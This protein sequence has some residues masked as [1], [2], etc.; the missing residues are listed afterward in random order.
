MKGIF[1]NESAIS[2]MFL[3]FLVN[4]Q[5]IN[6]PFSLKIKNEVKIKMYPVLVVHEVVFDV[7]IALQVWHEKFKKDF[8]Y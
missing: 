2:R 8:I 6:F 3:W 4:E 7:E 5:V 1:H